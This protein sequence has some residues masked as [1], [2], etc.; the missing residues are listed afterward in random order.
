MLLMKIVCQ[1]F[2][3]LVIVSSITPLARANG[4][5]PEAQTFES[6][7]GDDKTIFLRTTFGIL[8]TRDG[9]ESWRWICERALGYE[10]QWDPPIAVT[11]D[12]RLWV[13]LEDGLVATTGPDACAIEAFPELDTHTVKDLTTDPSGEVVW[14]ITG[15]PGKTSYVWRTTGRGSRGKSTP[16][17]ERL[18]AFADTN[19]MTIE[20]AP[21]VPTSRVYLSGQ[22]YTT[23]RGQIYR[24]DDGG[25]TFKTDLGARGDGGAPDAGLAAAV[26]A[27]NLN[28][29]GPFF[30]GA[31]DQD[32]PDRLLIRHL[33]AAGSDLLRSTDG[34][35]TFK[36]VLTMKSA[37]YGFARSGSDKR[38]FFAGSGLPEHGIFR[39]TDRGDTFESTGAKHGV[40]CMKGLADGAL[41]LCN[42]ALTLGGYAIAVS[43]DNGATI[44]P[45]TRFTDV[46]G[47]VECASGSSGDAAARPHVE[48]A[49]LCASSWADTKASFTLSP[50]DAG[51][52]A[53]K[54]KRQIEQQD[55]GSESDGPA[56][57]DPSKSSCGCDV[58]GRS[59]SSPA[60]LA[61]V[62]VGLITG[63]SRRVRGS[64]LTQA[65]S[66][67]T[68]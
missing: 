58:V 61:L 33:H 11:R 53:P 43:R 20:V 42:N 41:L 10:G 39:S 64:K 60:D 9:G 51:A 37:M 52:R 14:A 22:P 57:R 35:R 3:V 54:K 21:S 50:E 30:I 63:V 45:I 28:A 46:R 25:K 13:G 23:I 32:D 36:N 16:T 31:V 15:A 29:D 27:N 6:V 40:L 17:F 68:T 5:F 59:P 18:A 38:I 7:P 12:G 4:R 56:K 65:T 55:G 62:I 19:L 49:S 47:P 2:I 26:S 66:N 44:K 34:G 8:V 67:C 24:S 1:L 48:R